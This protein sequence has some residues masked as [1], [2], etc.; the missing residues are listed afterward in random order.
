MC[1]F[2]N[3]PANIEPMFVPEERCELFLLRL[4]STTWFPQLRVVVR[5]VN[6]RS[7]L[8][9]LYIVEVS[10]SVGM[11]IYYLYWSYLVSIVVATSI[12]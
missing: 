4:A 10:V 11:S 9:L 5:V 7:V 1:I 6:L 3:L 2:R 8:S 12:P